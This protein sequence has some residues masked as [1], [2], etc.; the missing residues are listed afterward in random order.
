MKWTESERAL[1]VSVSVCLS[2][3]LATARYMVCIARH[4]ASV[5]KTM[6]AFSLQQFTT[7]QD[8]SGTILACDTGFVLVTYWYIKYT[9]VQKLLQWK[10][11]AAYMTWKQ[12]KYA[13]LWIDH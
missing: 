5:E 11:W 4:V 2:D 12:Q 3:G 6:P 10:K 13:E 9:C 7:K 8:L 1:N